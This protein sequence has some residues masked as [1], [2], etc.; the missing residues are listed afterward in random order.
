[1]KQKAAK[2]ASTQRQDKV[3][4][5]LPLETE[6]TY[7]AQKTSKFGMPVAG[8]IQPILPEDYQLNLSDFALFLSVMK[9]KEAYEDVLSIILDEPDLQ[10][11]E[12]KVEQVVLNKSGK[13]AIRL[14]AWAQDVKSR[15]FDMEMQNDTD[16]DDVRKRARYYQS[17]LDIPVLKSGKATR[18]KH[19]PS[20]VIIFITQ[21]DIFGRDRAMYTFRERCEE[22]PE[23]MLDDG[24][25]KIF[26]N[27]TSRKGRPELVSLLQYMKHTTLDNRDIIV[28]D[29]RILDL[30]RI[31]NEVMQTEEWEAVKMNILEIGMA[32]GME[33]GMET[34]LQKGIQRG[35]E[36]LVQLLKLLK[37]AGRNEDADRAIFDEEYR[38]QLYQEFEFL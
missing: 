34:G 33:R 8:E 23:L 3:Y 9:V 14:D 27:M 2:E 31:V 7:D 25:S 15:Q 21:E 29:E 19:L 1:M 17:L 32:Q 26:L 20:T 6:L 35:E 37:S 4:A 30:D 10:L 5:T 22:E 11:K 38:K 13:R 28:R 12:I 18:Y 16:G 24:T 36:R